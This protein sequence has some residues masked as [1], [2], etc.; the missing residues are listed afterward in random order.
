MGLSM[1]WNLDALYESFESEKF[2]SDFEDLKKS[3]SS[4]AS[5]VESE[6]CNHENVTEKLEKYITLA[7]DLEK[8]KTL[9]YYCFLIISVDSMNEQAQKYG[10]IIENIFSKLAKPHALFRKYV[11]GIENIDDIIE[12]SD[13]L[14]EHSFYLK[15]RKAEAKY[16]LPE[17]EE[18]L[19][20][21]LEITGSSAWAKMKEMTF[22]TLSAEVS[23]DGV[24]KNLP[25]PEIRKIGRAHV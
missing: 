4:I 24:V 3:I 16:T 22:S 11:G 9:E 20:A 15:E 25:M 21:S 14:K 23:I 7:N 6:F 10:D 2:K 8:Y 13:I 1:K 19:L 18:Q 17:A 12:S 5:L